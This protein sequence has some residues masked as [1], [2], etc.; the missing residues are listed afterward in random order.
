MKIFSRVSPSSLIL[1]VLIRVAS[2]VVIR[3]KLIVIIKMSNSF[4]AFDPTHSP[5]FYHQIRIIS[6]IQSAN[7]VNFNVSKIAVTQQETY[8]ILSIYEI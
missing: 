2:I 5:N 8:E 3:E 4:R 1:P 7:T 6:T